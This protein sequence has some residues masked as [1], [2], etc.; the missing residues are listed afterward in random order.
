MYEENK[1]SRFLTFFKSPQVY[2]PVIGLILIIAVAGSVMSRYSQDSYGDSAGGNKSF[3][4]STKESGSHAVSPL[5][6]QSYES[7]LANRHALGVIIENHPDSRPQFGLADAAVVYEAIAEGGITRF[8]AIFGP[9]VPDKVGPVRSARTYFLDWCLEYDCFLSHVGG[10]IDALDL[11]PKL[12]IKD[13]DQFRYGI[14]KYGKTYYRLPRKDI[15]TEHTMFTDP[16][17]LYDIA[18]T[19]EWTL[20][21]SHPAVRFKEDLA[22]NQRPDSQMIDIII[23]SQQFDTNWNYE[24]SSNSYAR[25]MGGLPHKD[26]KSGYQI[27]SKALIVQ[28]VVSEPIITRINEAGQA[29]TTVGTGQATIFQDGDKTTGSWRKG[30][31]N[32]RTVF[33]DGAGAEIRFNPGNR[34]ITIVK[35]GTIINVSQP[36]TL[37]VATP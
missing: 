29:M 30:T 10:N 31:K 19:N 34:W 27:K 21:G 17:R 16:N 11:I 12:K 2:L 25:S 22:L 9:T 37:P 24:K 36:A 35:P 32:E 6:G 1:F 28:E 33:Y 4:G 7:L 23:S 18:K 3:F 8:L 26:G 14:S 13:L 5:D 15:P 20:T